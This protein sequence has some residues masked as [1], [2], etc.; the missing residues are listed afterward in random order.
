ML[1]VDDQYAED[2][3]RHKGHQDSFQACQRSEMIQDFEKRQHE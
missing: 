3:E 2:Q 1:P